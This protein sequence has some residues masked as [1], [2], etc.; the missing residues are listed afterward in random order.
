MAFME[1]F[2]GSLLAPAGQLVVPQLVTDG[3]LSICVLG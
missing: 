1:F 2:V 3:H